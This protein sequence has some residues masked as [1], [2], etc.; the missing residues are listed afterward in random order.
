MFEG[1]KEASRE[2]I[3]SHVP[4]FPK[5]AP[6][7]CLKAARNAF[8]NVVFTMMTQMFDLFMGNTQAPQPQQPQQPQLEAIH[9]TQ[10][11][12]LVPIVTPP[13]GDHVKEICKRAA[14]EFMSDKGDDPIM[15]D[16]RLSQ[17]CRVIKELKFTLKDNLLCVM[18]LLEREVYQL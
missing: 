8:R 10:P 3:E 12:P 11:T 16:Q 18:S 13:K 1:S 6:T 2:E 9:P 14:K 4:L 5:Q 17:V 7:T 15:A